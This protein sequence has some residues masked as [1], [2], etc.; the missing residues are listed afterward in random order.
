MRRDVENII[1]N[2][3]EMNYLHELRQNPQSRGSHSHCFIL[4]RGSN[5]F[6]LRYV[7]IDHQQIGRLN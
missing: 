4:R 5:S 1:K 3:N 6:Y 2:H 7:S